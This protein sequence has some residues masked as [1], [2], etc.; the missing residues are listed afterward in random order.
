VRIPKFVVEGFA[1]HT[2]IPVKKT[3]R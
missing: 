3:I 1:T 2:T